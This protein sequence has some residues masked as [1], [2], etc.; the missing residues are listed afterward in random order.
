MSRVPLCRAAT[1]A[2]LLLAAEAAE[3][4]CD[5]LAAAGNPCVVAHSS[6]VVCALY[7]Q[8]PQHAGPGGRGL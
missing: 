8:L 5:I 3:G 7:A 2:Q 4:P 6:D 1:L